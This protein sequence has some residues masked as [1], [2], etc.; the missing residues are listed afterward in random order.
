M[1]KRGDVGEAVVMMY[2]LVVLSLIALVILGLSAVFYDYYIDVKD[3]EA[4]IVGSQ[5]FDC[6]VVDGVVDFD[7]VSFGME[8]EKVLSYCGFDSPAGVYVVV[9]LLDESGIEFAKFREGDFGAKV[10]YEM[11]TRTDSKQ[12]VNLKKFGSGSSW[13][14]GGQSAYPVDIVRDG[15]RFEG[16]INIG[17]FVKHE[18]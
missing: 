5:I 11:W 1:N 9:E 16:G 18:F 13:F 7:K 2:R 12:R 8:D 6:L 10:I 17:V 4:A 3:S 14:P 15:S